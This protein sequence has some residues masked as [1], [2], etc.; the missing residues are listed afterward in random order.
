MFRSVLGSACALSVLL[1]GMGTLSC[2]ESTPALGEPVTVHGSVQKG[3]FVIGSSV[4]VSLLDSHLSPTGQVYNTQTNSDRGEFEVA[5]PASGPVSLEGEGFY[6]NEVTGQLSEAALTL[7]AFYAPAQTADQRVFINMVTHL[8]AERIKTLVGQG[9]AFAAAVPQAEGELVR[10]LHI[11]SD[12]YEPSMAGVAMDVTGGDTRDNAYLLGVSSVLIQ[13]AIGRAGSLDASLQELLN[14]YSLDLADDGSLQ[15]ERRDEVASALSLLQVD[16]IRANLAQRL[17]ELGSTDT[18]P[19]MRSALDETQCCQQGT[20]FAGCRQAQ[21]L[22]LCDVGLACVQD[23]ACG[24]PRGACCVP[25]GGEGQPCEEIPDPNCP[26]PHLCN[27]I[28]VCDEGLACG[29]PEVGPTSYLARTCLPAG[30]VN[31]PCRVDLSCDAGLGCVSSGGPDAVHCGADGCCVAAGGEQQPCSAEGSCDAGL[32]CTS[33]AGGVCGYFGPEATCC[34]SAAEVQV[35]CDSAT[36]NC[37][38]GQTCLEGSAGGDWHCVATGG[39]LQPCGADDS[40]NE[41]LVCS[42]SRP[43]PLAGPGG[44]PYYCNSAPRCCMPP[45][46]VNGPDELPGAGASCGGPLGDCAAGFACISAICRVAGG[47]HEACGSDAACD[48]DLYCV[49]QQGDNCNIG[50]GGV[51]CLPAGAAGQRCRPGSVCDAGLVCTSEDLGPDEF[52]CLGSGSNPDAG[53]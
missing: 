25:A 22:S 20:P 46:P 45:L 35:Q 32:V 19:D 34:L 26:D 14:G 42:Q 11:T 52:V 51:C 33:N 43:P 8:T 41:G 29:S 50:T 1:A 2:G 44:Q 7:R 10:Q 17:S 18:V 38:D 48:A 27:V 53:P 9:V 40:C 5:F 30:G 24:E 37:P 39:Q 23:E 3:P 31:Q 15:Q 21:D 6:F 12:D 36:N 4:S 49:L 16:G 13:V 47:L 28:S